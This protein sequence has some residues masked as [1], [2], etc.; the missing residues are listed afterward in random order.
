MKSLLEALEAV[1]DVQCNLAVI[2]LPN[3]P[4]SEL[5]AIY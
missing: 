3:R 1:E 4:I 2:H 5:V